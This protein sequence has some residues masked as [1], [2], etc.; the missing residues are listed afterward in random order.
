[1]FTDLQQQNKKE[2]DGSLVGS[3]KENVSNKNNKVTTD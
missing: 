2:Q 1:V 3:D